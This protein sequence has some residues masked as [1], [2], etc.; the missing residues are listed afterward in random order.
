MAKFLVLCLLAGQAFATHNDNVLDYVFNSGIKGDHNEMCWERCFQ[1]EDT[2]TERFREIYDDFYRM[3]ME[4]RRLKNMFGV[5]ATALML[6]TTLAQF[7]ATGL[8]LDLE[9]QADEIWM[10][11][12]NLAAIIAILTGA[13]NDHNPF[14]LYQFNEEAATTCDG[15][16]CLDACEVD[17]LLTDEMDG[18]QTEMTSHKHGNVEAACGMA[19]RHMTTAVCDATIK[20]E[21]AIAILNSDVHFEH[22]I[23]SESDEHSSSSSSSS[24]SESWEH[25]Q[26]PC[27][28]HFDTR[29]AVGTHA[30]GW[31]EIKKFSSS[32]AHGFY[33]HDN[34][35]TMKAAATLRACLSTRCCPTG[36]TYT[37]WDQTK[38]AG[39]CFITTSHFGETQTD[40]DEH[41][42]E[43]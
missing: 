19:K 3:G 17:L 41:L 4:A 24:S 40:Y 32:A 5:N 29:Y 15:F 37:W 25:G 13:D 21:M 18:I 31:D 38:N 16:Q 10:F 6:D 28:A 36:S 33:V 27:Y 35:Y 14:F 8:N 43:D 9:D 1:V 11:Q 39:E 12:K 34:E 42:G 2:E 7:H 23:D 22:N 30:A 26:G 20:N